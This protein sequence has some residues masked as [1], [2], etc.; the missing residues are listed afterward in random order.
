ME[1]I[2]EDSRDQLI[3]MDVSQMAREIR[4]GSS[5]SLRRTGPSLDD[6]REPMDD[7]DDEVFLISLSNIQI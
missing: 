1:V 7:D 5:N 4:S 2:N 3:A 6:L